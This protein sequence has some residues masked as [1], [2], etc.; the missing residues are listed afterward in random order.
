MKSAS[1]ASRS[2]SAGSGALRASSAR[3]RQRAVSASAVEALSSFSK[4][5]AAVIFSVSLPRTTASSR[6]E[7]SYSSSPRS[8][9]REQRE[10]TVGSR[11]P[12]PAAHRTKHTP[13]GG[14]SRSLRKAFCA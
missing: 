14:S 1:S 6:G 11:E 10:S 4:L 12:M 3:P 2:R 8:L 7:G 13:F 9:T 5:S